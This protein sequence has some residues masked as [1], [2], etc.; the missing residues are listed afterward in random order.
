MV[1]R[2]ITRISLFSVFLCYVF[3]LSGV[4]L[5]LHVHIYVFSAL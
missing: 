4:P 2:A 1:P 5:A 3:P